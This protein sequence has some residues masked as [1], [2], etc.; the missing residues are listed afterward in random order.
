MKSFVIDGKNLH[1]IDNVLDDKACKSLHRTLLFAS[2]SPLGSSSPA[3]ST[4][5]EV[6][7]EFSIKDIEKSVAYKSIAEKVISGFKD[8][9]LIEAMGNMSTSGDFSFIHRDSSSNNTTSLLLFGN[10]EWDECNGGEI[11]F[12][13]DNN[14][15]DLAVLPKP[16]RAILF[17]AQIK[18]K[19]GLPSINSNIVRLSLSL[20]YI[21]DPK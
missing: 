1:V 4:Y 15:S 2:Y 14:E 18:H 5:D 17:D 20:R 6:M 11:V 7:C 12:Y 21:S 19:A 13:C 9:I 8:L 16:G 3:S 10:S